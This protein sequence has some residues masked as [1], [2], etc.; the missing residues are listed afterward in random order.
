MM[1][2]GNKI[3]R[4]IYLWVHDIWIELLFIL[5][6]SC[7]RQC[8]KRKADFPF[9]LLLNQRPKIVLFYQVD[10]FFSLA[11]FNPYFND[12]I[13]QMVR[14]LAPFTN[15]YFLYVV[16]RRNDMWNKWYQSIS[17]L[18]LSIANF[19]TF[20]CLPTGYTP[21]VVCTDNFGK[22]LRCW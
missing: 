11:T 10:S 6:S 14:H 20:C 15:F 4:I 17:Q 19:L 12:Q 8:G 21:S 1:Q 2:K 5:A 13:P 16:Q 18:N 9:S 22:T 7:R 3:S